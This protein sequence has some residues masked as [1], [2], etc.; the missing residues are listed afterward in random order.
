M[1]FRGSISCDRRIPHRGLVS[2]STKY[3]GSDPESW[4]TVDQSVMPLGTRY[5]VQALGRAARFRSSVRSTV[6]NYGDCV[7]VPPLDPEKNYPE[8]VFRTWHALGRE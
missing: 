8:L 5:L 7:G 3:E 2:F 4:L 1:E 6:L